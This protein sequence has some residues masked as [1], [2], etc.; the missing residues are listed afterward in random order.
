[1]SEE[2]L[3]VYEGTKRRLIEDLTHV[4]IPLVLVT[5]SLITILLYIG[6]KG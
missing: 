6:V 4:G 3:L 5:K 2:K 1:M